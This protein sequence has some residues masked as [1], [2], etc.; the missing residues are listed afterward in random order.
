MVSFVPGTS[1]GP[2]QRNCEVEVQS[3]IRVSSENQRRF[4]TSRN[5]GHPGGA[6]P[7]WS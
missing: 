3:R 1:C 4:D 2:P 7:V 6:L 5:D